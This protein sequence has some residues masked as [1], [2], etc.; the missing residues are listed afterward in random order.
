MTPSALEIALLEA[1]EAVDSAVSA[2]FGCDDSICTPDEDHPEVRIAKS[3]I[4][5]VAKAALADSHV[6]NCLCGDAPL[7]PENRCLAKRV[8]PGSE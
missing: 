3:T 2:G 8:L 5:A 1:D 4:R 7:G 6:Q